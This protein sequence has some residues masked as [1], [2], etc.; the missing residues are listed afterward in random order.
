MRR[1]HKRL[2]VVLTLGLVAGFSSWCLLHG[3]EKPSQKPPMGRVKPIPVEVAPEQRKVSVRPEMYAKLTHANRVFEGLITHDFARIKAGAEALKAISVDAP[4][5]LNSGTDREDDIYRHFRL[6]FLRLS[7]RLE[8]MAEAKS[9]EGAAYV[10]ENLNAT[11]IAC[12]QYLRDE[13]KA[14]DSE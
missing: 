11:C 1:N 13:K 4:S 3:D 8:Q 14:D 10:A 6:E 2:A 7:H 5:Y 9:F 12:H